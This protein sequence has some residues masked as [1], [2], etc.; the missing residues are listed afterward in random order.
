MDNDYELK[1]TLK[2]IDDSLQEI[3]RI[4][5]TKESKESQKEQEKTQ[6]SLDRYNLFIGCLWGLAIMSV[7]LL[8]VMHTWLPR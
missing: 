4:M 3:A 6:R 2:R 7:V 5:S 1:T 8:I